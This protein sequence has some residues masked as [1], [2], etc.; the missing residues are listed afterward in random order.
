MKHKKKAQK[1]YSQSNTVQKGVQLNKVT[2]KDII[3]YLDQ[4]GIPFQTLVKQLIRE[5]IN[6]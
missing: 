5:A 2:D 3:E 6:K 1:K 4:V